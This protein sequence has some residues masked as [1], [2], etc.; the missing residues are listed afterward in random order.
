MDHQASAS[1]VASEAPQG[2]FRA[3][4]TGSDRIVIE[5][6]FGPLEISP[7]GALNFANGLFGFSDCRNF[8]LAEH[9]NPNYPHLRVLQCLDNT[10][11]AFLVLTLGIEN[12]LIERADIHEACASIGVAEENLGILVM[13]TVRATPQSPS[14]SAN[15]C[16]PLLIDTEN[17]SGIQYVLSNEKYPIRYAL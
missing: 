11:V 4:G 9:D 13:V 3:P 8:A 2:D 7:H 14:I 5:S 12:N 15:L 10:E 6:R 16:A 17:L 1:A